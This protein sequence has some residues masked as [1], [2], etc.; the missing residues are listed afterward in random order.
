MED[1]EE[2]R[3]FS[4]SDLEGSLTRGAGD[5]LP[6]ETEN[7]ISCGVRKTTPTQ[8]ESSDIT[9]SHK[10]RTQPLLNGT[11]SDDASSRYP[12]TSKM[13]IFSRAKIHF[14][15]FTSLV[16]YYANS[17]LTILQLCSQTFTRSSLLALT[18]KQQT[19]S[20][21]GD[22]LLSLGTEASKNHCEELWVT[23]KATQL[24]VLSLFGGA[25][26]HYLLQE[27]HIVV[28][29][30]QNWA[31]ALYNLRHT[32][33]VEGSKELDR[34]PR[35]KL[36]EGEREERKKKAA[37]AFKKFLPSESKSVM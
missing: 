34:S 2:L 29:K 35:E 26:D 6:I 4:S 10:V 31:R 28:E 17:A 37:D 18:K 8:V 9:H 11:S 30:E 36:T 14:L 32:L 24:A 15:H 19:D 33:W 1:S 23:D 16:W 27:L 20:P 5:N 21:L 3:R 25:I 7:E 22:V 12:T 13:N